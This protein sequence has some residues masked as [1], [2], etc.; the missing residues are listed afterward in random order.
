MASEFALIAALDPSLDG[1]GPGVPLGVGD[2]AAVVEVDGTPVALCVDALVEGVHFDRDV[3]SLEDVGWKALAVNLSD[4]AAVGASPVAAVVALH[5]PPGMTEADGV[6]VYRGMRAC[7]DAWDVRLVG[8]DVVGADRLSVT[9]ALVGSLRGA[10]PLRRDAATVGDRVLVVGDLGLAAAGLALHTAG[11]H[12]LL[13]AHPSLLA[14]HRRP[15]PVLAAGTALAAGGAHACID[16]SDGLG[17]DL[18]HVAD[19]SRVGVRLDAARLPRH[20]AVVAAAA[21]LDADALDLVVGGGDDYALAATVSRP[22]LA[23]VEAAL[24]AAG[25]TARD[26]GEVTAGSG[27]VLTTDGDTRDVSALGWEHGG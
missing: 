23:S 4:L 22:S 19:R 12:D 14:A 8:G 9:V 16:V 3:S 18:G 2:D 24:D 11:H 25:L 17:R 5:A 7:A 1:D 27:V 13:A 26:I 20:A 21:R 10:R 6:A 15:R